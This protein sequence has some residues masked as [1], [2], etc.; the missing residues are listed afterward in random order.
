MD[1]YALGLYLPA[2]SFSAPLPATPVTPPTPALMPDVATPVV[3]STTPVVAPTPLFSA[4]V[5]APVVFP[6]ALRLSNF[7]GAFLTGVDAVGV[8]SSLGGPR[9]VNTS[10]SGAGFGAAVF[11]TGVGF[12]VEADVALEALAVD[13]TGFFVPIGVR[14]GVLDDADTAG[15]LRGVD[16]DVPV[17]GFFTGVGPF[18][19]GAVLL[20]AALG[21]GFLVPMGVL[22]GLSVELAPGAFFTDDGVVFAVDTGFFVTGVA[23]GLG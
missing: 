10:L 8:E 15:F 3:V 1:F 11:L 4:P 6:M 22:A 23:V 13:G 20:V 5:A 9:T 2:G 18:V 7:R 21:M 16:P 17:A 14:A 19:A 12:A